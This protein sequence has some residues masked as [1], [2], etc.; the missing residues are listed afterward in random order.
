[1][2][3][4]VIGWVLVDPERTEILVR[5]ADGQVRSQQPN[6]ESASGDCAIQTG[7]FRRGK[8][9]VDPVTLETL[10]YEIEQLKSAYVLE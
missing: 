8:R 3:S 5:E 7:A 9:V 2:Q 1:M 6:P 10:G 4:E